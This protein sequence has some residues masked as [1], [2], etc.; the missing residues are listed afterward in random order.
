LDVQA[1]MLKNWFKFR[2]SW[3]YADEW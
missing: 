2:P 1:D 3:G